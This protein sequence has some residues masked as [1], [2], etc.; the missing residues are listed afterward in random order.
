MGNLP[1][2]VLTATNGNLG[3]LPA[4]PGQT[5]VKIGV[6][7][8]GTV[9]QLVSVGSKSAL[10]AQFGT[11]RMVDDAALLL[12]TAG[13]GPLLCMRVNASIAGVAGS[14]AKTDPSGATGVT[15]PLYGEIRLAGADKDGNVLFRA[16]QA[17]VTLTVNVGMS[18]GYTVSGGTDVTLTVQN[19]TTGNALEALSL[20]AAAGL[21]AQPVHLGVGTSVCGQTLAKTAF[22]KGSLAIGPLQQG[23]RYKTVVAGA[24]NAALDAAAA[25]KDVTIT[26]GTDADGQIDPSKNTGLLVA[27]K[28][29]ANVPTLVSASQI[30]DGS[31]LVG[32]QTSFQALTFGSTGAVSAS[33]APLD[34]Y[35]VQAR[36]TRAGALGTA[37][38]R[39]TTDGYT[40]SD[41]LATPAGGTYVMAGTGLTLT[42][43]GTF[44]VG[45]LFGFACSA[46]GYTI[47][48]LAAA[49]TAL[50]LDS[51]SYAWVHIIGQIVRA[52]FAAIFASVATFASSYEAQGSYVRFVLEGAGNEAS[53]SNATWA[54]AWIALTQL[55]SSPRIAVVLGEQ[56]V[57]CPTLQPQPARQV[58]RSRA[59]AAMA[60]RSKLSIGTDMGDQTIPALLPG[61]VED[62]H[63]DQS[64]T[65]AGARFSVAYT[66]QDVAGFLF[67]GRLFDTFTGDFKFWQYGAVLDE[68]MR[69]AR[70][71]MSRYQSAGPRVRKTAA[72][73]FP[74]GSIDPVDQTSMEQAGTALIREALGI[75]V[76]NGA[77]AGQATDAE[78]LVDGTIN[79]IATNS[80]PYEVQVTPLGYLKNLVGKAGLVNPAL[81]V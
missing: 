72:G 71:F 2:N 20:G 19:T 18:A 30:G 69:V 77:P 3:I 70:R 7:S 40:W 32:Q 11:G 10:V 59:C 12:D 76:G 44:A 51:R 29:A 21:I 17:G 48:D 60:L 63:L 57:L 23:V 53:E 49:L 81:R 1:S 4:S 38:F 16:L 39:Y 74:A 66:E 27:A 31:G 28:L 61:V 52:N 64:D 54:N 79:L 47:S 67:E 73:A 62:Y 58:R 78:L 80:L 45:D 41:E 35:L 43:S 13:H 56:L 42:L 14:V 9:N 34:A 75:R 68:A 50:Q 24:A 26:L 15:V 22:D 46:P 6:C 36:I 33:G 8:Q 37:A 5:Q 65:L 55:L 25:G